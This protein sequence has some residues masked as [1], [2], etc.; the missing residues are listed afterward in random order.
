VLSDNDRAKRYLAEELTLTTDGRNR[1]VR[2]MR[3]GGRLRPQSAMLSD[4]DWRRPDLDLAAI[5]PFGRSAFMTCEQPARYGYSRELGEKLAAVRE[6]GF[7]SD[8]LFARLTTSC[9]AISAGTTFSVDHPSDRFAGIYLA[10]RVHV[11]LRQRFSFGAVGGEE[12]TYQADIEALWCAAPGGDPRSLYRPLRSTPRPHVPGSQTAVV[13]AEV[14]QDQE[15]NVGGESDIGCVR[16]RFHWDRDVE[17][18]RVEPTSCWL[19]V[20]QVFAGGRGHGAMFHPRVG[21]EVIVDFLEGDP[22]RPIITGRVYNGRNLSP[23][24][25]TN[26]PTYS[27]I[28]SMTSPFNGNYNMIAFDDLQGEEKFIIHVAKDFIA[29]IEHNSSRCVANFDEIKVFGDQSIWVKGTQTLEVLSGQL[30]QIHADQ[31]TQVAGHQSITVNAGMDVTVIGVQMTNA[32]AAAI[33]E[34]PVIVRKGLSISDSAMTV[35]IDGSVITIRG[36]AVTV[37]GQN[38]DVVGD[39]VAVKGGQVDIASAGAVNVGAGVVNVK[40][41][42]INLNC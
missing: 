30:I 12:P 17:R 33:L 37:Q 40:G 9:R 39:T 16:V 42:S 23:E 35:S 34:A 11:Q 22:D 14:G 10:R 36:G 25:A 6:E 15:I 19:R 32:T 28:K 27:C 8:A 18:H 1:E 5:S 7:M 20:S 38:V 29:N 24:N 3:L 2:D 31:I 26:R 13:T 21:D 41:G 4:Y